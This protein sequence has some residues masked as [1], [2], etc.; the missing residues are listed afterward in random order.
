MTSI[1]AKDLT[2]CPPRSPKERLGGF[3]ILPRAI[4]KCR[5]LLAGTNG[6]YKFD[7]SNDNVLFKFKGIIGA[8]LKDYIAQGHTDDEIVDWVKSHGLP[9]TDE[10]IQAWSEAFNTDYSYSTNPEKKDWFNG[11][12]AK[13]GLDPAKTTLFE[14]LEI[15]DKASFN[16]EEACQI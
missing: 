3:A 8:E 9:K 7:C 5:A 15:D 10:E 11:V 14:Y 2:K 4:D 16:T 13:H 6:E 12:C 1:I